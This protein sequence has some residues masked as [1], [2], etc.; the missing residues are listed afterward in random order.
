MKQQHAR[1]AFLNFVNFFFFKKAD[2]FQ[3]HFYWNISIHVN[4]F[5]IIFMLLLW[6]FKSISL[7]FWEPN[8]VLWQ[9]ATNHCL[10]KEL[11]KMPCIIK[12]LLNLR[13]VISQKPHPVTVYYL[14]CGKN[15]KTVYQAHLYWV[16]TIVRQTTISGIVIERWDTETGIRNNM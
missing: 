10:S 7:P 11:M 6:Y 12:Q 2:P 13:F 16:L 5:S 14:V 15:A 1:T 3:C 8:V 9:C 4:E